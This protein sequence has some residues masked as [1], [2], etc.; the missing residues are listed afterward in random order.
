MSV[1]VTTAIIDMYGKCGDIRAAVRVFSEMPVRNIYTWNSMIA[2]LAMNGGQGQALSLFWKMQFASVRPN[3][4]TF[5]GLLSAC[6][7]SG[8]VNEGRWLFDTMV[9]DFGI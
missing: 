3:T 8:R 2:G 6:S 1:I 5:V 9:E 4:I 7:H